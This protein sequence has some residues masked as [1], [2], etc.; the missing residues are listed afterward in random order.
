MLCVFLFQSLIYILPSLLHYCESCCVILDR[1]ITE[2]GCILRDV[3]KDHL[4]CSLSLLIISG[5]LILLQDWVQM[6]FVKQ[7]NF[8]RI[9]T[10]K[11]V[12]C[13]KNWIV[14]GF[15][16]ISHVF[17]FYLLF[18]L[19]FSLIFHCVKAVL[20]P[21]WGQVDGSWFDHQRLWV[22]SMIPI[23]HRYNKTLA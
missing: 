14:I 11:L 7:L 16:I 19:G 6:G 5:T 1:V 20:Y 23:Q 17:I 4:Q 22:L 8:T 10:T 2:P 15:V 13:M 12:M 21:P 9:A 3:N 18:I